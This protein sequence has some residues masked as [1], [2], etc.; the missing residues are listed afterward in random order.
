MRTILSLLPFEEPRSPVWLRLV[1]GT[2]ESPRVTAGDSLVTIRW[3]RTTIAFRRRYRPVAFAI[4]S[5]RANPSERQLDAGGEYVFAQILDGTALASFEV[6]M[7]VVERRADIAVEVPIQAHTPVRHA[8]GQFA[9]VGE[10]REQA[11]VDVE[12]RVA[13]DKLE[14]TPAAVV[15]VEVLAWRNGAERRVLAGQQP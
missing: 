6:E 7:V 15:R 11:V 14:R 9:R 1:S 5:I 4:R 12:V 13:G 10:C 8:R 2:I 3:W